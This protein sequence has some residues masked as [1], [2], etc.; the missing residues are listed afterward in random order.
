MDPADGDES[1]EDCAGHGRPWIKAVRMQEDTELH[2]IRQRYA[3]ASALLLD[4]YQAGKQ[5]GTGTVFDWS[6][7]PSDLA[8]SIVLA[9]GLS[10]ENVEAA[11]RQVRPYAVDVSGGVEQDKG[12]KDAS[13]I[14]AF[15]RGVECANQ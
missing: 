15:I 1:P 3:G 8:S 14:E 9:G 4:A 11:I 10:P 7:V 13:K 6:C 2:A 5:G 12:I